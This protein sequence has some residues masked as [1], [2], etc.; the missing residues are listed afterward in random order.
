M[1][2]VMSQR[3]EG[4]K[5]K[6]LVLADKSGH[7]I[8]LRGTCPIGSEQFYLGLKKDISEFSGEVHFS[9]IKKADG[10]SYLEQI[11]I[12]QLLKLNTLYS[13]YEYLAV[14]FDVCAQAKTIGFHLEPEKDTFKNHDLTLLDVADTFNGNV[15]RDFID[16]FAEENTDYEGVLNPF[17]SKVFKT[18]YLENTI[19]QLLSGGSIKNDP[20][21]GKHLFKKRSKIAVEEALKTKDKG[22]NV[23][24][25][26]G[27]NYL[28][29]METLIKSNGYKYARSQ[30]DTII[31]WMKDEKRPGT[32]EWEEK[33]EQ[34]FDLQTEVFNKLIMAKNAVKSTNSH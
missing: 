6:S 28:P 13:I 19:V 10:I 5:V 24:L 25:I 22:T 11:R 17:D 21:D 14:V 8:T 29:R 15:I 20:L 9:G 26:W 3:M 32:V 31:P 33:R 27:A 34:A 4:L 2:E 7:E 12:D 16:S 30:W 1:T 18:P 23:M